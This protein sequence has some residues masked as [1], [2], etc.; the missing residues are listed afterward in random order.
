MLRENWRSFW[1]RP[2]LVNFEKEGDWWI[3]VSDGGLVASCFLGGEV[4]TVG[5]GWLRLG[6][7]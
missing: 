1:I 6:F 5:M 7:G 2:C 3:G 4:M